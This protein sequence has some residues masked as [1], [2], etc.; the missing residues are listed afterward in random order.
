[1]KR[2]NP[3]WVKAVQSGVNPC[4]YFDLQSM[5]IVDIAWGWARVEIELGRK[6]LQPFGV[7]HGGVIATIAD[8]AGFW[9]S[10]ARWSPDRP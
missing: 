5:R 10:T 4:P 8:A 9:G 6:H 2:I 3:E 7:V 1:M